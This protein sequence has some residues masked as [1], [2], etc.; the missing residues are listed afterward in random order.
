MYPGPDPRVPINKLGHRNWE[1]LS[2]W[3]AIFVAKRSKTI[4][5]DAQELT[6]NGFKALHGHLFQD[7]YEW[8][9]RERTYTT[10]RNQGRGPS[11]AR[12]E[13]IARQAEAQFRTFENK[14]RFVG[15]NADEFAHA[16]ADFINEINAAHPFIEGNGRVQRRFLQMIAQ[17]AA[18]G[19]ELRAEDMEAWNKAAEIGFLHVNPGP[20]ATLIRSRIFPLGPTYTDDPSRRNSSD[21]DSSVK[22]SS[23]KSAS[24][25]VVTSKPA[26]HSS[27]DNRRQTMS[28]D[29]QPEFNRRLQFLPELDHSMGVSFTLGKHSLKA[30]QKSAPDKVDWDAVHK[31]T[32]IESIETHGQDPDE[33]FDA[34]SKFSPGAIREDVQNRVQEAITQLS[35][36]L[37]RRYDELRA[38]ED[39][40]AEAE[41]IANGGIIKFKK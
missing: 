16:S 28:V 24:T 3:E 39:A 1:D 37:T 5:L 32:I 18:Y 30:L 6:Y 7:I 40:A 27:R 31:K 33:V 25:P 8:A 23:L 34:I 4:P 22:N 10:G 12:P 19:L 20:T 13:H 15:M 2:H 38:K 35:P 26:G 11:F 14:N 29:I 41:K 9:G 21:K 36:D 17:N